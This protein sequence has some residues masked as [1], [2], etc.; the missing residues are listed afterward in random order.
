MYEDTLQFIDQIIYFL[1]SGKSISYG[2]SQLS[3]NERR[4]KKKRVLRRI[5]RASLE[6]EGLIQFA[7]QI[8]CP[9]H[10]ALF[11]V[12]DLGLKG[13]SVQTHLVHLRHHVEILMV[14]AYEKKLRVMPFKLLMPMLFC[15]FPAL[16]IL[17][18]N[19]YIVE[20][21]EVTQGLKEP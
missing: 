2:L 9:V 18:L 11:C 14:R 16:G 3:Q 4:S 20:F 1:E 12:I 17:F 13:V 15:F 7:G 6:K 19:P 8:Q 5:Y 21:L 10:Q